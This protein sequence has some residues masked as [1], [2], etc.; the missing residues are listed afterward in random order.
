MAGAEPNHAAKKDQRIVRQA[1]KCCEEKQVVEE[2]VHKRLSDIGQTTRSVRVAAGG[3]EKHK[4]HHCLCWKEIR[5]QIPQKFLD[6]GTKSKNT[7]ERLEVAN[8]ER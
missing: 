6:M 4:L 1:P 2:V 8:E 3:T 7:K 5:R